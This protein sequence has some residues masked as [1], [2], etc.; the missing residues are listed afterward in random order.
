MPVSGRL[1]YIQRSGQLS[2]EA[3][4]G[5]MSFITMGQVTRPAYCNSLR[6]V[7]GDEDGDDDEE[8]DGDDGG[9]CGVDEDDEKEGEELIT[10]TW[11]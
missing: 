5:A 9:C 6:I 3:P 8:D 1:W 7:S 4:P 11:C 10:G 2:Y